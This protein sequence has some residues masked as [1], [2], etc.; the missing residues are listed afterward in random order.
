M[1]TNEPHETVSSWLISM[2]VKSHLPVKVSHIN[3]R[4]LG[5]QEVWLVRCSEKYIT[6]F[7][8]KVCPKMPEINVQFAKA[9]T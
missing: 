6:Y 7:I 5:K 1:F 8:T 9:A 3:Y 2:S 4:T